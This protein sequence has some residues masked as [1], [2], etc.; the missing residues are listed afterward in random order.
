MRTIK[1]GKSGVDV[2]VIAVG[3]MRMADKSVEEAKALLDTAMGAGLN[4]FD[5][6]DLYGGGKSEEVF[7]KAI[8]M[9]DDVREKIILQSK[10]GICPGKVMFDFSK[11]HIISS[12]EG[13]LS[14]LGVD[15]V[16]TLLLHRPDT[17]ME[18]E[19]VAEAFD[20]LVT[21]GKVRHFG[22]SNHTPM[23]IQLLE[24]YLNQKL[25]V[26]QL[27]LSL[28][29]STVISTGMETNTSNAGGINRDGYVL[30]FCRLNDI[31]VQ[32]WSPFQFGRIAGTFIGNSNF[33]KLN[34]TINELSGKYNL[35]PGG[36]VTAWILRHPAN[37]QMITGTMNLNHLKEIVDATD[38]RLSR[39]DWYRL[40]LDAGHILL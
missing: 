15:Y 38:V 35:T 11:E 19:E 37:I 36:I 13:S 31:T 16:D 10:C 8:G 20:T 28:T 29:E 34:E 12:V 2:P 9:N 22:V 39:E 26:N 4:F 30:D 27:Q 25:L 3:C 18:P 21:S 7:S 17:L 40:Y 14:R 23:Q 33:P 1:L 6:A 24:R 32:A 5:H